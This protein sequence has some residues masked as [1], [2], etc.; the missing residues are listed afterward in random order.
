MNKLWILI[1]IFFIFG[2]F[3]IYQ[4]N[5]EPKIFASHYFS[6]LTQVGGNVK[7]VTTHAVKDYSWLP[8][9]NSTT[10]LDKTEYHKIDNPSKKK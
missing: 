3:M 8:P 1:G 7:D 2:G 6:W 5:H 10:P 9:E 4:N